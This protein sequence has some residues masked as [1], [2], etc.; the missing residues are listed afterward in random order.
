MTRG[1]TNQWRCANGI[2]SGKATYIHRR[3]EMP[4]IGAKIITSQPELT[5]SRDILVISLTIISQACYGKRAAAYLRSIR[6]AG[7]PA[8]RF[9]P[10]FSPGT[11]VCFCEILHYTAGPEMHPPYI[12]SPRIAVKP[13]CLIQMHTRMTGAEA[14]PARD[15]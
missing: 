2:K 5:H 3:F 12:L 14:D 6:T 8:P 1:L 9:I 13:A 4:D 7:Q 10:D 11:G 15:F